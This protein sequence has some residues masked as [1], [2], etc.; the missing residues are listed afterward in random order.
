MFHQ[1]SLSLKT[2]LDLNKP[3]CGSTYNALKSLGLPSSHS[4]LISHKRKKVTPFIA[5]NRRSDYAKE[6]GQNGAPREISWALATWNGAGRLPRRWGEAIL[7][8][9]SWDN[10]LPSCATHL[11]CD[12]FFLRTFFW[13][14]TFFKFMFLFSLWDVTF[15]FLFCRVQLDFFQ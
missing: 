2:D 4:H 1:W 9:F 8:C 6:P 7:F 11:Q 13:R 5:C 10:I 14:I 3:A 12:T 15:L